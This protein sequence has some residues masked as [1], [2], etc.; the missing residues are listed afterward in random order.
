MDTAEQ[1]T[2]I[3]N[4]I[5][6]YSHEQ[7]VMLRLIRK[8]GELSEE[9]FDNIFYAQPRFSRKITVN[10]ESV[11]I[12][13]RRKLTGMGISGNSF[14]LG[15]LHGINDRDWWLDLLQHMCTIGDVKTSTND[16]SIQYSL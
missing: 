4:G 1:I 16:G 11:T 12:P 7:T 2:R 13:I 10:G 5:S 9:H 8:H 14:L 6:A 15:S 3:K